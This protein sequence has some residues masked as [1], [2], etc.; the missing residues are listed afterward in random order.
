MFVMDPEYSAL[1]HQS[2]KDTEK[3]HRP[4]AKND[5]LWPEEWKMVSY[6]SYDRLPKVPLPKTLEKGDLFQ[7]LHTRHTSRNFGNNPLTLGELSSL[8]EYSCG[9]TEIAP[10]GG[11][12]RRVQPSA[13]HRYPIEVYPFVLRGEGDLKPGL[14][15]YNVKEHALHVLWER[16]FPLEEVRKLFFQ[17]EMAQASVIFIMTAVFHRNQM[18]YGERGY[19]YVL[20]EAGHIGQNFHLVSGALGLSCCALGGTND[21]AL[22]RLLDIDGIGESVVYAVAIGKE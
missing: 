1:F 7:I 5:A 9:T 18:K 8:L 4:I 6:K 16:A 20:L 13:G 3:G 17:K 10:D 15:H 22:E 21:E 19:R 14:Y 11:S 2:S 12:M